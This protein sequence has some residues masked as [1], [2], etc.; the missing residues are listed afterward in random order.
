[1]A[2]DLIA[3]EDLAPE[4][5]PE[6]KRLPAE[7]A[8]Y[9]EEL[10]QLPAASR[11]KTGFLRLCFEAIDGRTRMTET[12]CSGPQV[13]HRALYLDEY[14]DDMAVVFIQS[15]GAGILQGDRLR[16]E[17]VV[18]EGARVL[19]TTQAASKAYTTE[20]NYAT[21][22]IDL[23]VGSGAY[24]EVLLDALIPYRG[25]RVYTELNFTVA[26]DAVLV[27]QDHVTPGRVALGEEFAYDCLYTRMRC[28]DEDGRLVVADTTVLEPDRAHPQRAG[29]LGPHTDVGT[30]YVIAQ[31]LP[32][33]TVLAGELNDRLDRLADVAAA[34]SVM[35]SGCGV[36]VRVLGSATRHVEGAL[37]RCWEGVR[38]VLLD[39]PVAPIH[40]AKHGFPPAVH[41]REQD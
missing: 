15:V 29:I 32:D 18:G 27:Y 35:P 20:A 23:V 39:A 34:A 25:A 1:M 30:M 26:R 17:I 14:L 11:G 40:V 8:R 7:F 16:T 13:V 33:P 41:E 37:H 3:P 6:V 10:R 9:E 38:R 21:Q 22:R 12:F 2:T 24:C 31:D 36:H 4:H 19:V 28:T 5:W